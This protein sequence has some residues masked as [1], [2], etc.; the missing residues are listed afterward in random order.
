M[1]ENM[2][3]LCMKC[4]YYYK[5]FIICQKINVYWNINHELFMEYS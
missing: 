3:L 1:Y 4:I 5:I 2:Q